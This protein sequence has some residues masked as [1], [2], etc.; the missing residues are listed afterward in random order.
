MSADYASH[1]V[2]NNTLSW[3]ATMKILMYKLRDL[4]KEKSWL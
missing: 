1:R 4:Y 2:C 3:C